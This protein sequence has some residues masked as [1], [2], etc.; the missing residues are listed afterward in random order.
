EINQLDIDTRSDIYSLGVLLYELLT[1]GPPFC[2]KESEQGGLLEMLRVIREQEPTTPSAKLSTAEGLPT[3]AA[4]RGTEPTKLT[5]LLRGE[6]DWI[7]LKALDKDR[8]RRYET[9]NGLAQDLQRHLADEPVH[10]C[11][12]SLGYRLRKFARRQRSALI[13]GASLVVSAAVIAVSGWLY[14]A[15]VREADHA[16][17][18]KDAHEKLPLVQA[19]IRR[20]RHEEAFDILTEIEACIPKYPDLPALWDQC[21]QS[22]TPTTV[23]T[24]ADVWIRAYDSEGPW[25]H[26]IQTGDRPL[27]VRVPRGE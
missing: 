2:R 12:P 21:S 5:K 19:A 26:V 25:R 17:N 27:T 11:P 20:G 4:N 22:S 1:G 9:A 8:N 24:G 3:L 16:R 23:P 10:A 13:V 18:V 6:L 15:A 14:R 7:V